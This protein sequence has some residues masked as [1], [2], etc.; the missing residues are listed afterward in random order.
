MISNSSDHRHGAVVLAAGLST[1]MGKPK[2]LLPWGGKTVIQQVLETLETAGIDETIVVAGEYF[3]EI[4]SVLP[5]FRGHVVFNPLFNN[6]EMIDSVKTGLK[7][8]QPTNE[9]VLIVMGDQPFILPELVI[10][11]LRHY[12]NHRSAIVIPRYQL[13]K[14]HPWIISSNFCSEILALG[15][16]QNLRDFLLAHENDINYCEINSSDILFDLDYPEDYERLKPL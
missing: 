15:P 9:D 3:S 4:S 7:F 12:E 10:Q 2:V 1:R 16:G 11:L 5:T 13:C 6:G 8:V 14:G